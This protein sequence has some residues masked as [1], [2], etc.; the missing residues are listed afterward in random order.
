MGNSSPRREHDLRPWCDVT[1]R[2]AVRLASWRGIAPKRTHVIEA[3]CAR[4][5]PQT[6]AS[7]ASRPTSSPSAIACDTSQAASPKH[8]P[9]GVH[10]HGRHRGDEPLADRQHQHVA[11]RD[12]GVTP[13]PRISAV[14]R[15]GAA[16]CQNRRQKL[17][18]IKGAL[19]GPE[20][21]QQK[22]TTRSPRR[23]ARAETAEL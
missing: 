4:R 3:T 8:Y 19:H 1:D 2:V 23:R 17:S 20:Q 9:R 7:S 15:A 6:R 13:K 21:V 22:A 11:H 16:T 12:H 5:A 10:H 18:T 14:S